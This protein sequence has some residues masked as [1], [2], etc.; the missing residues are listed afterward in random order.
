M[1]NTLLAATISVTFYVGLYLVLRPRTPNYAIPEDGDFSGEFVELA[2]ARNRTPLFTN[3]LIFSLAPFARETS[4]RKLFRRMSAKNNLT[5]I[6]S[7]D[8]YDAVT[9]EEKSAK[10]AQSI[11]VI[12]DRQQTPVIYD[13]YH[14]FVDFE[15]VAFMPR[16]AYAAL[17][18]H[19]VDT[20]VKAFAANRTKHF[21][22]ARLS[23]L[24]Q[25]KRRLQMKAI[26][27]STW[28][29]KD[30]SSCVLQ[31]DTE[32]VPK[33]GSIR[34]SLVSQ[35]CGTA[36][37]CKKHLS[38]EALQIAKLNME[39]QFSVVGVVGMEIDTL[40]A[41]QAYLPLFMKGALYRKSNLGVEEELIL[42]PV[43]RRRLMKVLALDIEL[44]RFA[45]RRLD[46]Q[47]NVLNSR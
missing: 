10:F 23:K 15:R 21:W 46:I 30:F 33:P 36:P 6:S 27:N 41:L 11:T 39:S 14:P 3:L 8:L 18:A 12:A 35:F 31:G 28:A 2:S 34:N 29:I 32:C 45:Q 43:V 9:D 17:V 25:K 42:T 20:F 19:P 5:H 40:R 16:P 44:F 38:R 4:A 26:L 47:N 24:P 37:D 1:A 22:Q 7:S 13:A